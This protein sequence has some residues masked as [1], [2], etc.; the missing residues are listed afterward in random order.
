MT[1]VSIGIE[2]TYRNALES[3][4]S[5]AIAESGYAYVLELKDKL[6]PLESM[7]I[8]ERAMAH[9]R[10]VGRDG[11]LIDCSTVYALALARTA[12]LTRSARVAAWAMRHKATTPTQQLRASEVLVR[13]LEQMF[14]LDEMQKVTCVTTLPLARALRDR[15]SIAKSLITLGAIEYMCCCYLKNF[16]SVRSKYRRPRCAGDFTTHLEHAQKYLDNAAEYVADENCRLHLLHANACLALFTRGLKS[17]LRLFDELCETTRQSNPVFHA[18]SLYNAAWARKVSGDMSDA[19]LLEYETVLTHVEACGLSNL[20]SAAYFDLSELYA[21]TG[22]L[23]EALNAGRIHAE[24]TSHV[25]AESAAWFDNNGDHDPLLIVGCLPLNTTEPHLME[26]ARSTTQTI[27]TGTQVSV[28]GNRACVNIAH[29]FIAVHI[30]EAF[31]IQDV[32]D[33]AHISRRTLETA[34]REYCGLSLKEWIRAAKMTFAL[35]MLINSDSSTAQISSAMGFSSEQIFS[36]EFKRQWQCTPA[37]KR[38][39]ARAMMN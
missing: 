32:A 38:K 31:K 14:A 16:S 2:Q 21:A 36:A 13:A 26:V 4:R 22:K 29:R 24:H 15:S 25:I 28:I 19:L 18:Y 7:A 39:F 11:R 17:S 8:L 10:A 9:F 27:S 23:E 5:N 1:V 12:Q 20:M 37:Q 34:V 3:G 6:H 30:K 35:D 33:A